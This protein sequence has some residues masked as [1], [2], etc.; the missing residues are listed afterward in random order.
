MRCDPV[1]Q[2]DNLKSRWSLPV[3]I[4]T[5]LHALHYIAFTVSDDKTSR[6]NSHHTTTI[7]ARTGFHPRTW[8]GGGIFFNLSQLLHPS[9]PI[10]SARC[11]SSSLL[12][13]LRY[14]A[15]GTAGPCLHC[16]PKRRY[17][18]CVIRVCI[19]QSSLSNLALLHGG[20]HGRQTDRSIDCAWRRD[21]WSRGFCIFRF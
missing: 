10:P 12:F 21:F 7:P 6:Q 9:L 11:V 3:G 5:P 20:N 1:P 13:P 14:T 15:F 16:M 8:G 17:R 18:P 4:H 2:H 19:L